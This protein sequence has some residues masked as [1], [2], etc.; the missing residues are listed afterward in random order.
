[1][2]SE[3]DWLRGLGPIIGPPSPFLRVGIGDDAAVLD[4]PTE[5]LVATVDA[6]VEG[7]HFTRAIASLEDIGYRSFMAAVSD[8]AAMAALPLA[9]LSALTLPPGFSEQDLDQLVTG[10]RLA[11]FAARVPLVGGNL[12]QGSSLSVTTTAL[13]RA[14][15]PT[16]RSGTV[17]GHRLWLAGPVGLAAAGLRAL[18]RGIVGEEGALLRCILAWRRPCALLDQGASVGARVTSMIDVSDGLAQDA[19]HLALASHVHL[20]FQ[21]EAV[22]NIAGTTLLD[23]A[24]LLGED[25]YE[26]A[27]AGGEDYALLATSSEDLRPQ[28]FTEVGRVV[29]G[30]PGITVLRDGLPWQPP[31]GFDHGHDREG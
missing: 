24:A 27:F 10:Q 22:V 2:K 14:A 9:T 5:P 6:C 26:L 21:A 25:P 11:A 18:L 20:I 15:H 4:P 8:L 31:P 19:M 30:P 23:A 7:V 3:H 17:P 12:S 16:L 29:S 1:M 13:G 28:G